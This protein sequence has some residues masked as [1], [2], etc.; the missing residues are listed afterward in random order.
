MASDGQSAKGCQ[1][2]TRP[3][4]TQ[5]RASCSAGFSPGPGLER[6][7]HSVTSP[8]TRV[9]VDPPARLVRTRGRPEHHDRDAPRCQGRGQAGHASQRLGA[10]YVE[11]HGLERVPHGLQARGLPSHRRLTNCSRSLLLVRLTLSTAM[12][13]PFSRAVSVTCPFRPEGEDLSSTRCFIPPMHEGRATARNPRSSRAAQPL[14]P[15]AMSSRLLPSPFCS[16]HGEH[17][18]SLHVVGCCRGPKHLGAG[19]LL[20]DRQPAARA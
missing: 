9:R 17:P 16:P 19:L 6:F 15:S 4:G 11:T 20:V 1:V 12:G 14:G 13:S 2:S 7:N 8:G 18:V 3:A 5:P 10:V